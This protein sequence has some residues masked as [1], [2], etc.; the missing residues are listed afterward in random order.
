MPLAIKNA[1]IVLVWLCII[2]SSAFAETVKCSECGMMC[3]IAAQF[4]SRIVHNDKTLYFCDIGD[5]F[6]YLKRKNPAVTR[7]EVKDYDTGKWIDAK[8]AY[9]VRAG[10]KFRTP[11]GWG[12]AAFLNKD[13]ASGY[14]TAMDFDGTANALK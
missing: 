11:M 7:V 6:S 12:I 3:D 2:T 10:N 14:G 8:K 5:L 9:Y 13:K 4:T 1:L